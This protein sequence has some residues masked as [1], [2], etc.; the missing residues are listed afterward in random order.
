MERRLGIMQSV[1]PVLENAI[2]TLQKVVDVRGMGKKLIQLMSE[3][4]NSEQVNITDVTQDGIETAKAAAIAKSVKDGEDAM[5][6]AAAAA[7]KANKIAVE[8]TGTADAAKEAN[9]VAKAAKKVDAGA[10]KTCEKVPLTKEEKKEEELEKKLEEAE[11]KHAEELEKEK[12]EEENKAKEDDSDD[13][14]DAKEEKKEE[15]KAEKKDEKKDDAKEEKK[16]GKKGKGKGKGKGGKKEE[17]EEKKEEKKEEV[18]LDKDG[19]PIC[20]GPAKE[21][22]VQ[23]EESDSEDEE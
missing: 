13:E 17:K 1:E 18:K 22:D 6:K 2:K 15:K 10:C 8:N 9:R 21:K 14:D 23:L 16:D 5:E 20:K 12:E 7:E 19:K 3:E 11:K 4:E